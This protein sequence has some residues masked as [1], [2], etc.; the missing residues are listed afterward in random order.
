MRGACGV[1]T[2][3]EEAAAADSD[4]ENQAQMDFV[5]SSGVLLIQHIQNNYREYYHYL[6]FMSS[7]GDPR[8]I[9]SIYFPVW[10]HLSP[11]V[12]TKMIWVAVFGDWLNLIFKW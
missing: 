5:H 4:I 9:F 6:S 12:G 10:F 8:N 2:G 7:V 1:L 3:V 11:N